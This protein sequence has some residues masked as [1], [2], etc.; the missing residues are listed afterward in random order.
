M[1][2]THT[3][4]QRSSIGRSVIGMPLKSALGHTQ[5][6]L[7]QAMPGD[8]ES[9]CGAVVQAWP[10]CV[11]PFRLPVVDVDELMEEVECARQAIVG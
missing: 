5:W 7:R 1:L 10:I 6:P 8:V 4:R 11:R 9:R 3:A 2:M